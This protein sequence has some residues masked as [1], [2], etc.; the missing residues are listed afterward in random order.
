M[1]LIGGVKKVQLQPRLKGHEI[2]GWRYLG[3]ESKRRL[4]TNRNVLDT[5]SPTRGEVMKG[6]E[7]LMM[8]GRNFGC[9][10]REKKRGGRGRSGSG[11]V[12]E[13]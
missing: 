5:R 9:R 7:G 6:D 8:E 11:E 10:G 2:G 3:L 1:C 12:R 13:V 4:S